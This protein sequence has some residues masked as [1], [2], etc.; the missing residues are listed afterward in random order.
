M[1]AL[2]Q[3]FRAMW[4][5]G[6]HAVT[7]TPQMSLVGL[8][9]SKNYQIFSPATSNSV[10]LTFS[11]M[12][13]VV[14]AYAYDARR[15][16]MAA[17]ET[18]AGLSRPAR[19][20]KSTAWLVVEAYY[21]AFFSAHCLLRLC[22]RT[23]TQFE[24][25]V[26]KSVDEVSDLF[27]MQVAPIDQGMFYGFVDHTRRSLTFVKVSDQSHEGLWAKFLQLLADAS[28]EIARNASS[29]SVQSSIA[30]I[31]E[32]QA[33]LT[34]GGRLSKGNW[35]SQIRN[36]VTY[37]HEFS[38]WYPYQSQPQYFSALDGRLQDWKID[39][40]SITLWPQ[41]GRD[42]QRFLEACLVLAS[43][44]REICLDMAVRCPAGKSFQDAGAVGLLR[45]VHA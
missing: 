35:L 22:G 38:A 14:N 42:I 15:F 40:D 29:S 45:R 44:C 7:G 17:V 33:L 39:V 25:P 9:G 10:T 13:H 20:P 23:F 1:S 31:I 3:E 34:D 30:K 28:V 6:I 2:S 32:L 26:T 5:D 27:G 24:R 8:L 18:M 12:S 16:S 36:R 41:T 4:F 11:D 21:G 19:L 37:R 43:L